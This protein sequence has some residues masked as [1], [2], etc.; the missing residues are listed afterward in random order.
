MLWY[1]LIK[2][3]QERAI[4]REGIEARVDGS[5]ERIVVRK[6]GSR[7]SAEVITASVSK[8]LSGESAISISVTAA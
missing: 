5:C 8:P 1:P 7:F 2:L 6:L 3:N 4:D